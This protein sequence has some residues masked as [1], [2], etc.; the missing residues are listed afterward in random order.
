MLLSMDKTMVHSLK[1]SIVDARVPQAAWGKPQARG[2]VDPSHPAHAGLER[3][4]IVNTAGLGS[5]HHAAMSRFHLAPIA[6]VLCCALASPALRAADANPGDPAERLKEVE[7]DPKLMEQAQRIGKK[8]AAFCANCHGEGGNSTKPDVPNLAG[9]N[10]SY[11]FDQIR[12]FADGRRKNMFMEGLMKALNTDE[13]VGL[14]VFYASQGVTPRP[15][16]NPGLVAKGKSYY[17]HVC[18][19]CHGET[20]LGNDQYAR[21]AGQQTEYLNMTIKR[22]RDGSGARMNPVMAA[23]TRKMSDAEVQAVVAYVASMK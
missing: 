5:A 23:T 19:A 9:Q 13:K 18:F 1:Q 22:Y 11:L 7:R 17:E 16:T 3:L 4:M 12:Q 6:L 20:G 21:I 14:A 8:T 15:V 2:P 10:I